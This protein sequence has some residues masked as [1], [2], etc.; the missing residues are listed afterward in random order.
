[1]G[2]FS[3]L[4]SSAGVNVNKPIINNEEEAFA[5]LYHEFFDD[6]QKDINFYN[7]KQR[8]NLKQ[9]FDNLNGNHNN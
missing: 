7:L 8:Y 1:M 6:T 4:L 5:A 2:F 3:K 9:W